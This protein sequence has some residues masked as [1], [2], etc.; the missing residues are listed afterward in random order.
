VTR[1][2]FIQIRLRLILKVKFGATLVKSLKDTGKTILFFNNTSIK[3][4]VLLRSKFYLEILKYIFLVF[5]CVTTDYVF[6]HTILL[7][8]FLTVACYKLQAFVILMINQTVNDGVAHSKNPRKCAYHVTFDLDLEHTL[9]AGSPGDHRVQV[10]WRSGH[11]SARR[12]DL[13]KSLQTDGRTDD[14]RRAIALAH[15]WNEL[16]IK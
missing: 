6:H 2:R 7:F 4:A 13:C 3:K 8:Y 5:H 15:S 14:G 10:W 11:V 12:S 1:K 9:D 16:K